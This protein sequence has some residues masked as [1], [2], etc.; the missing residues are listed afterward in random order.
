[1]SKMLVRADTTWC[2]ARVAALLSPYYEKGTPQA[3]QEM[4]ARDWLESLRPYPQWAIERAVRWWKGPENK[5][6]HRRPLEGDIAER[7]KIE[8]GPVVSALQCA[9]LRERE[10]VSAPTSQRVTAEAAAAILAE[11]GIGVKR[12]Q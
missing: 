3:I 2:M 1:M 5:Y 12:M 10:A 11:Y 6:R 7:C 9:K 4:D 8:I